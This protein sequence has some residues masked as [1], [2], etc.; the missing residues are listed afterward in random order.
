MPVKFIHIADSHLGAGGFGNKMSPAGFNQREEDICDAF[1]A[2][3]DISLELKPDF[4]IHA[5]DLFHMVRPTNRIINFAIRELLRLIRED[6]PVVI[7]SG[8]HDAPKQR[9]V[10][11]VLSIFEN[12]PGVYPVFKSK[13]EIVELKGVAI[14][15]LPHCL[16]PE[17]LQE[18]FQNVQ[19]REGLLN[20]LVAHGVA[21]GIDQFSM[22]EISEEEIPS[23]VFQRGFDYIALG[24]YH[25]YTEVDKGV[26]YA[27]STE[28]LSFNELGEKKG[29]ME[30]EIPDLKTVFHRLPAREMIELE[31]IDASEMDY[32]RL[33]SAIIDQIE[34]TDLADKIVRLKIYNLSDALYG[35]LPVKQIRA[36]TSGAFHFKLV[37]EK[38]ESVS[39]QLDE[40]MKFGHLFDEFSSFLENR[41]LEN[42]DK[43]QI[44]ELAEKYFADIEE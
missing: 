13:Y 42:L 10:G 40:S 32:E 15:C 29:I 44:L 7:I 9:S 26:Y 30:V 24:H 31:S 35:N 25:K 37:T 8:N 22:A 34:S 1:R 11:H 20:I 36:R 43:K 12:L 27:G 39:L 33:E 23:S 38:Q 16:T 2:A 28:R 5:G 14:G 41:P 18:Q 19:P 21:A 3:I 17:I 4:V 6:I